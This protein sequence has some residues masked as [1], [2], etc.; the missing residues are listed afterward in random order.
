M[1]ML[2]GIWPIVIGWVGF[3]VVASPAGPTGFVPARAS[4]IVDLPPPSTSLTNAVSLEIDVSGD[5]PSKLGRLTFSFAIAALSPYNDLE[6]SIVKLFRL[7]WFGADVVGTGCN[8][9]YVD[10]AAGLLV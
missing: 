5:F 2:F 7:A 1:L 9:V 10:G 6:V 3:L 8:V 4:G